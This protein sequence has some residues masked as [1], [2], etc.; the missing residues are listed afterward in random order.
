MKNSNNQTLQMQVGIAQFRS[1][2]E[3]QVSKNI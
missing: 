3:S 1:L 2:Y